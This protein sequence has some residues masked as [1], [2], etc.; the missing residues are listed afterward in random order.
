ME[1]VGATLGNNID[2]AAGPS[3]EFGS[4][5]AADNLEFLNRFLATV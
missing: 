4:S 5:I 3:T 2:H 1:I